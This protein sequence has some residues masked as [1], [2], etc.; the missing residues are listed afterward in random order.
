MLACICYLSNQVYAQKADDD[1]QQS[2]S[3][4]GYVSY[5]AI[6]DSHESVFS[7]DGE[8]YFYPAPPIYHELSGKL[9]NANPQFNMLSLQSRLGVRIA[10]PD[11]LGAKVTGLV[12]A[13]FFATKEEYK[14]LLRV[15]HAIMKMQWERSSLILGQYWHPMFAPEVCPQVISYGAAVPFNPLNRSPQ[16]RFEYQPNSSIRLVMAA[17]VHG[18]Y[19]C[20]GP[21]AAQRNSGIP[22]LQVQLHVGNSPKFTTGITVGYMWLQ[23]LS[24]VYNGDTYRSKAIIGAYN[25]QWFGKLKLN[26][27]TLQGKASFGEN[28]SHFV[29]LGGYGRLFDDASKMY[30]YSYTN[31]YSA[32]GW[33]EVMYNLN[34][35]WDFG[36]FSGL[37]G[38]LGSN[39]RIDTQGPVWYN[40]GANIANTYRLSPRV[41]YT[42]KGIRFALE[43]LYNSAD[44]GVSLDN[45][46]KPENITTTINHRVLVS[47]KYSF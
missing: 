17:L 5:E 19:S 12:E 1:E 24:Q 33:F 41:V 20:I 4:Y 42:Q 10:G 9:I 11:V 34:D 43:Y 31:L 40:R 36:F 15:R 7:R 32:A 18:Y 39:D 44:Y 30:D 46:G 21:E 38:S 45:Y 29:M 3:F 26:K 22:D 25:L 47:A 27:I 6:F 8:L 35:Y 13:D 23:P 28:M 14:H 16:I 2:F 37:A